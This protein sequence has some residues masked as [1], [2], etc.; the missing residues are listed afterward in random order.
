ML[1]E[2]QSARIEAYLDGR[3][4]ADEKAAFERTLTADAALAQ[5]LYLHQM[6]RA[7]VGEK[8]ISAFRATV[9]D[10]LQEQR[11]RTRVVSTI[12]YVA[13][14]I[15]ASVALIWAALWFFPSERATNES[16]F[17][18]AFQ[19]PD[20]LY[21]TVV[22]TVADSAVAGAEAQR[23]EELNAAWLMKNYPR[24]LALADSIAQ[25]DTALSARQTAAYY[26]GLVLLAQRRAAPALDYLN[27]AEGLAGQSEN[28]QWYR[29]LAL[30]L[31]AEDDPARNG[32]ARQAFSDLLHSD[33]PAYRLKAARR[34]L[35]FL[36]R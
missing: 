35:T 3:L 36:S 32:A 23:W 15:A 24:A 8:E 6:L 11:K 4:D 13:G 9:S 1:N 7:S 16:L 33:Q 21:S 18:G 28:I 10:L 31:L 19:P 34:I 27:Q 12:W 20:E 25:Q 5:E 22:R 26:A 30:L 17:A 14:A 2:E 29:A